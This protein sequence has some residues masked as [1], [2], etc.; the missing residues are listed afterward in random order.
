MRAAQPHTW[1]NLKGL[2]FVAGSR[3]TLDNTE[4]ALLPPLPGRDFVNPSDGEL[5]ELAAEGVCPPP[6]LRLHV[7]D[8]VCMRRAVHAWDCRVITLHFRHQ[9]CSTKLGVSKDWPTQN[10]STA[11]L[12]AQERPRP[13]RTRQRMFNVNAFPSQ[14]CSVYPC[15]LVVTCELQAHAASS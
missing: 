10:L 1:Q 4:E 11:L 14:C 6:W 2:G 13:H 3:A 8:H 12:M 7:A 5:E 15:T 9:I